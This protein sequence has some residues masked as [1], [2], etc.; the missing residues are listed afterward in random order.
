MLYNVNWP[1]VIATSGYCFYK[2][3]TPHDGHVM[4]LSYLCININHTL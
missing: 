4:G 3:T 2:K 1:S